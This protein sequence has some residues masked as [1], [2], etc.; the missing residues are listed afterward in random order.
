MVYKP[1]SIQHHNMGWYILW[2]INFS[3]MTTIHSWFAARSLGKATAKFLR[4]VGVQLLVLAPFLSWRW[5][6]LKKPTGPSRDAAQNGLKLSNVGRKMMIHQWI[7]EVRTLR[8]KS[9]PWHIDWDWT[10]CNILLL[11]EYQMGIQAG[12]RKPP[13]RTAGYT[14]GVGSLMCFYSWRYSK[15]L[16]D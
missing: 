9:E 12:Y 3:E 8:V 13:C 16:K 6:A 5:L 11:K 2:I 15:E 7:S 4:V 1:T 14:S 10:Y